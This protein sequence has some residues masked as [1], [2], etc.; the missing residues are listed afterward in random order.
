MKKQKMKTKKIVTKRFRVS[1]SGK[2]MHRV[3]GA[4]HLRRK[5]SKSR[6]RRQ[7][8]MHE[9]DATMTRKLMPFIQI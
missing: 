4:R 5:K 6:Q 2:L 1:A 8:S 9:L 3:Q 7:D